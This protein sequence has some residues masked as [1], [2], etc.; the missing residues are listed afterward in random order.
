MPAPPEDD[1]GFAPEH[2]VPVPY[3]QRI[4][5]Y[6]VALGYGAPYRWA[7]YRD[8][9]FARL[10]KPLARSRVALVTTAAPVVPG[11]GDQGPWAPYNAKP[12]FYT[13]Y[14]LDSGRDHDMAVSHVAIDFKHT[15]REDQRTFFPL[16]ALREAAA[17]GRIGEVAP[18]AFGIPTNRSHRVT[19][20]IDCPEL[21]ARCKADGIDAAVLVPNCPVCHQ[22]VTLAARLLEENGIATVVMACARDIVEHVGAPRVLFSDFPLGNGAGRPRD[23]KSQAE[24]LELALA[25]LETAPAPRTT[26]QSPLRWS[27]DPGWKLDYSNA[28]RMTAEEIAAKRAEFDAQKAIATGLREAQGLNRKK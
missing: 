6:Y 12:K 11:M 9:P 10:R 22:T 4:R 20:G 14:G 2:D 5:D 27:A 21:L 13:V 28:A 19:L 3:L 24:T 15:S 16:P 1:F 7:H 23:P 26:V 17:R 18:H 25:V 8:V